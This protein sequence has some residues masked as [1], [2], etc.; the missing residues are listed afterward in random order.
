M[1]RIRYSCT[2]LV[3]W[4]FVFYNIER[5]HEPINLASFVY[6]LAPMLAL[7]LLLGTRVQ[8]LRVAWLMLLPVPLVLAIKGRLGYPIGGASLPLTITELCAVDTTVLLAYQLALSIEEFRRTAMATMLDHFQ[9]SPDSFGQGQQELYREIQRARLFERPAALLSIAPTEHTMHV[10]GDRLLRELQDSTIR[11]YT[12]ARIADVLTAEAADCDIITRRD[13]HFVTL[14]PEANQETAHD[15]AE[16]LKVAAKERLG[17]ELSIGVATF[18]EEEV[19]LVGLLDRAETNMKRNGQ[20]G[21]GRN[22]NAHLA[23]NGRN[24]GN[25]K[26]ALSKPR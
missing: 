13:G 17:L 7:P 23:G 10:A 5:L 22:G 9:D 18:P 6:V 1:K 26:H 24:G 20:N 16:K 12:I 8:K 25:G 4:L 21:N 19:T 3:V 11:Q 14:M 2:A 15:A